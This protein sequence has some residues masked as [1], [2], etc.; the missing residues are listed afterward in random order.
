MSRSP[1]VA[2]SI[3]RI[4]CGAAL[5]L[6]P[7]LLAAEGPLD[8]TEG[9]TGEVFWNAAT[10][11]AGAMTAAAL[12]LMASGIL[13]APAIAG[14][15]R[16]ARD[17]GAALTNTGAVL[18][19]LGGAGHLGMGVLYVLMLSLAGGDR[20]EMIAYA[21]RIGTN[22]VVGAVFFP[23]LMFFGLSLAFLAWG[24]WRA[25]LIG[26]WGPIVTTLVV[27]AHTVLPSGIH[28]VELAGLLALLAVFG[29]LGVRVLRM[30]QAEWDGV[31][32]APARTS[33][34]A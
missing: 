15:L 24:A 17:R 30:S 6:F 32:V 12:M 14:I 3:R 11:H 10:R 33:V 16:Q 9:G 26:V 31:Q 18:G 23:M 1:S 29:Y 4:T 34:A 5:I 27:V 13:M 8:P 7:A 2:R 25:G 22:A 20:S 21:D 28:V 19:V